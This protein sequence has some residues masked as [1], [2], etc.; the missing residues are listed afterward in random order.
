MSDLTKRIAELVKIGP[1]G[2]NRP[3]LEDYDGLEYIVL[4][5][6]PALLAENT[7]LQKALERA[8]RDWPAALDKEKE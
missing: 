4:N 5:D 1:R 3:T 2:T 8:I 7:R 6:V